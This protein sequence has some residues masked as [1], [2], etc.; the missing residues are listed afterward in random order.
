M[1]SKAIQKVSYFFCATWRAMRSRSRRPL[2]VTWRNLTGQS[3]ESK[4]QIRQNVS[5]RY[6]NKDIIPLGIL[7]YNT[8]LLQLLEAVAR[9][10]LRTDSRL[11]GSVAM[12]SAASV[13][14]A[15]SSNSTRS[16][17]VHVAGDRSFSL[18]GIKRLSYHSERSTNRHH[19]ER[20]PSKSQSWRGQPKQ[21]GELFQTASSGGHM[22]PQNQLRQRP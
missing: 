10:V 9:N 19:M 1:Q 12:S 21:G 16:T 22:Q 6:Q 5:C 15:K 11:L 17:N 8:Q 18:R 14:L 4:C 3:G 13:T 7:L 20:V 2:L